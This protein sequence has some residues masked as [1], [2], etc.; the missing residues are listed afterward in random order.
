M[1]LDHV[2][3]PVKLIAK[4][5]KGCFWQ[6]VSLSVTFRFC[7]TIIPPVL[8]LSAQSRRG[9]PWMAANR[10]K[11]VDGVSKVIRDDM[12]KMVRDRNRTVLAAFEQCLALLPESVSPEA[13]ERFK[14]VGSELG[15]ESG[16]LDR[17]LR[18][19]S[20]LRQI[21]IQQLTTLKSVLLVESP[22]HSGKIKMRKLGGADIEAAVTRTTHSLLALLSALKEPTPSD[23]IQRL[24][25]S[26]VED[27]YTK[28][29]ITRIKDKFPRC[30]EKLQRRLGILNRLRRLRFQDTQSGLLRK[31]QN[32]VQRDFEARQNPTGPLILD[33]TNTAPTGLLDD[34]APGDLSDTSS[35]TSYSSGYYSLPLGMDTKAPNPQDMPELE[36]HTT[37][38]ISGTL[39]IPSMP[40]AIRKRTNM[41]CPFCYSELDENVDDSG[42]R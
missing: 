7:K 33:D 13:R 35:I 15:I 27:A 37:T 34:I 40:A 22:N 31:V 29:D 16:V 5:P 2:H 1:L 23:D 9:K 10:D 39:Q 3:D 4:G 41:R 20:S 24:S 25:K 14:A 42:W 6:L 19:S 17:M 18:R 21:L 30:Q 38:S 8:Q 32:V 26:V 11:F 12:P 28:F 36:P